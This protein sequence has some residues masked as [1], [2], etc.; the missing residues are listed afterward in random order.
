MTTRSSSRGPRPDV[1]PL[2]KLTKIGEAE[3]NQSAVYGPLEPTVVA[4]VA[5]PF[6]YTAFKTNSQENRV[7]KYDFFNILSRQMVYVGREIFHLFYPKTVSPIN[8][9]DI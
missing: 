7:K 2:V 8:L 5:F 6:Q 9:R 4:L 3:A 1:G